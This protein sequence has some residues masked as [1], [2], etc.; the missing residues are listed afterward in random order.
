MPWQDV[1]CHETVREMIRRSSEKGMLRGTHLIFGP[2][3]AGQRQIGLALAKTVQC[4]QIPNDFC[5]QCAVCQRIDKKAFPDVIELLPDEDWSDPEK[6]RKRRTYSI[7]HMRQ[8][9]AF[10]Q[11]HPYEADAKV[12]VMHE[13]HRIE[14]EAAN[15]LLK[16]LEEPAPHVQFFLLTDNASAIL[17]T[18]DSRCRKIPL[19]PLDASELAARLTGTLAPEQAETIARAANGLPQQAE[20]L[21]EE[22]YLEQRDE[23]IERLAAVRKHESAMLET[24]E[25]MSKDK[26]KL[27]LRL[28]IL[29]NLFRDGL[30][31]TSHNRGPLRNPDQREALAQLWQN[32]TP[33]ALMRDL[34]VTLDAQQSLDRNVNAQALLSTLWMQYR[35]VA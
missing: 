20:Q 6:K 34:E 31:L 7:S 30:I 4:P 5:D 8:V 1:I 24:V 12:F 19:S 16:T 35:H 21:I 13:A 22:N 15:C 17:P 9:I 32:D 25:W 10:A 26:E 29:L 33:D 18:I 2:P 23:I 28:T 27:P 14:I 11:Q 3:G